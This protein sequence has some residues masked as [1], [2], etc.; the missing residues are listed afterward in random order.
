[1]HDLV[2]DVTAIIDAGGGEEL[3]EGESGLWGLAAVARCAILLEEGD[4]FVL[5]GGGVGL[6]IILFLGVGVARSD[7]QQGERQQK[8]EARAGNETP[9]HRRNRSRWVGK[10]GSPSPEERRG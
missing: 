2:P 3:F 4:E 8:P 10:A 5:E 6:G 7:R 9:S 1:M